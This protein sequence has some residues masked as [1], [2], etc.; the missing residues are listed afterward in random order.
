MLT[1]IGQL[2]RRPYEDHSPPI[3]GLFDVE[4]LRPISDQ[5]GRKPATPHFSRTTL[6]TGLFRRKQQALGR[7]KVVPGPS[8]PRAR[9]HHH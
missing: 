6:V 2:A 9:N 3:T 4:Q 5:P 7:T 8:V 1:R